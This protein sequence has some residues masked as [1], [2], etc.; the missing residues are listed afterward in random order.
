LFIRLRGFYLEVVLRTTI[1]ARSPDDLSAGRRGDFFDTLRLDCHALRAPINRGSPGSQKQEFGLLSILNNLFEVRYDKKNMKKISF[2]SLVL[3]LSCVGL[4]AA[5]EINCKILQYKLDRLYFPIG[6][7]ENVYPSNRFT[8]YVAGDSIYSGV[9][10]SSQIG[11]SYSRTTHYFFDTINIDS[12]WVLIEAADIDSTS[13]IVI[14]LPRDIPIESILPSPVAPSNTA[15]NGNNL[16]TKQYDSDIDMTLDFESGRIDGFFSFS[17]IITDKTEARTISSYSPYFAALIPNI[18]HDVNKNGLLTKSLYYRFDKTRLSLYFDGDNMRAFNCFYPVDKFC[19]TESEYNWQEGEDLLTQID[20][21]PKQIKIYIDDK[22]LAKLGRYYADVLSRDRIKTILTEDKKDA[23][24]YLIFV[25]TLTE[26]PD[27]SLYYMY[28]FLTDDTIAGGNA[29]ETIE[30]IGEYLAFSRQ[31]TSPEAKE[32]YINLILDRLKNEIG[33]FPLF[34]P[35]LFFTADKQLRGF[36]FD[37][38]G[39]FNL[40]ALTKIKLSEI[41]TGNKR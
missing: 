11:V 29:N 27:S 23:D 25:P 18:S 20:K 17:N 33:A 16:I 39:H 35:T 5:A 31:T 38:D 2:I 22:R 32:Y 40:L 37:L 21:Y 41:S 26:Q 13:D 6:S 10:E 8:V 7:E 24:I 12:C 19:T 30:M 34:Q 15:Q 4:V 14:G 36:G 1:I 9:I 28:N 3:I